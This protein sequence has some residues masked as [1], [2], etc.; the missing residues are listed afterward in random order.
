M[1]VPYLPL[2]KI[3]GAEL[4]FR[5]SIELNSSNADA[6][7]NLG[8]LI[9]GDEVLQQSNNDEEREKIASEAVEFLNKA[10]TLNPDQSEWKVKLA[11]ALLQAGQKILTS[12]VLEFSCRTKS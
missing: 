1:V 10:V 5:K 2:N 6:L 9:S 12:K 7:F 3:S 4:A 11:G 8:Q